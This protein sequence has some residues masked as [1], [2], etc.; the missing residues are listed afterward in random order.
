[1]A[2]IVLDREREIK[3]TLNA[4]LEFKEQTGI[5]LQNAGASGEELGIKELRLLLWLCVV[6]TEPTT[7]VG[8]LRRMLG[9]DKPLT[10]EQVGDYVHTGNLAE[11]TDVIQESKGDLPKN[12]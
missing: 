11:I 3:L 6:Q 10:L 7:I 12:H 1:M 2:K 5:D 4:M 9:L 8:K